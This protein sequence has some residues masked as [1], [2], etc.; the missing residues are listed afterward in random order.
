MKRTDKRNEQNADRSKSRQKSKK[1][2]TKIAN[3][4]AKQSLCAKGT[5]RAKRKVGFK[6]ALQLIAHARRGTR[7]GGIAAQHAQRGEGG[8]RQQRN[9][10][11]PRQNG[12]PLSSVRPIKQT[13]SPLWQ[14]GSNCTCMIWKSERIYKYRTFASV[15]QVKL[16]ISPNFVD[17]VK[18]LCKLYYVN[19]EY[20]R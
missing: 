5:S 11:T 8:K 7:C 18:I 1:R 9:R 12:A 2:R 6:I 10:H 20:Q 13:R 3:D 4:G 17:Y 14:S 15:S 19:I 16:P